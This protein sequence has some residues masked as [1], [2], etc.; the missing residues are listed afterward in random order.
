MLSVWTEG[1]FHKSLSGL[2]TEVPGNTQKIITPTPSFQEGVKEWL[3]IEGENFLAKSVLGIP[4]LG[5]LRN[6][7]KKGRVLL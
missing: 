7:E 5:C 1:N 4:G 3:G 6:M 2:V